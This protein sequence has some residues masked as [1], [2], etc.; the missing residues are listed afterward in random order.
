MA[1]DNGF[2]R[3]ELN[4]SIEDVRAALEGIE[5]ALSRHGGALQG[6]V[7][8]LTATRDAAERMLRRL[9]SMSELS[10]AAANGSGA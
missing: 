8:E 1:D 10:T 4:R 5:G 2:A 9:V 7:S 3:E 6:Q